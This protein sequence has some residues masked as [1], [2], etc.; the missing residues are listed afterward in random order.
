M[1]AGETLHEEGFGVKTST[2]PLAE[3]HMTYSEPFRAFSA[4]VKMWAS[5]NLQ[6]QATVGTQRGGLKCVAGVCRIYPSFAGGKID[7]IAKHNLLS[8]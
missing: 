3:A 8:N 2:A 4:M 5:R 1:P 7:I 6:V